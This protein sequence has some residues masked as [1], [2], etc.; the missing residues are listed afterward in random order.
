[1]RMIILAVLVVQVASCTGVS[2]RETLYVQMGGHATLAAIVDGM[3]QC[4][5]EDEQ[6]FHYFSETKISRFRQQLLTHLCAV[7]GGP[8]EYRGDSM[9]DVH[10]GMGISEADFNHLVEL[11]ITVMTQNGVATPLQNRLLQRLAPLRDSI[12]AR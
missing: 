11:L 4:I 10:A 7:T 5:G 1:M 6:I 9:T 12:I 3:V 2:S 8:C